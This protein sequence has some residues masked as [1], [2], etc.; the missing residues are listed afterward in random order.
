MKNVSEV[1]TISVRT[2]F[3]DLW[4]LLGIF[5]PKWS[6]Q[7]PA[8][9]SKFGGFSFR[10]TELLRYE[11]IDFVV[12]TECYCFFIYISVGG[13]YLIPMVPP[14]G[15]STP[16]AL[17]VFLFKKRRFVRSRS[18]CFLR[19]FIIFCMREAVYISYGSR[20]LPSPLGL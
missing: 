2:I 3:W 13:D 8:S 18:R 14:R 11:V 4:G 12:V 19:S 17:K 9:M 20:I 7:S 6:P 1:W 16:R 10:E 5:G 15:L